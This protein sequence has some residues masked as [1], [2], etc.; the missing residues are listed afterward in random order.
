MKQ[1]TFYWYALAVLLLTGCGTAKLGPSGQKKIHGKTFVIIGASSGFGRGVAEQLGAYKA[2]VVLAARRGSVLEE[3]AAGIRQA[4]GTALVV[5][6]DISDPQAV[7]HLAEAAV[8]RYGTVDVWINM[9]GVGAIGRF[10]EIPLADQARL[11]DVNLTGFIYGSYA[12]ITLFRKQGYGTLINMGSV[13]SNSPIAYHASYAATK[14]GIL[15]LGQAINQE[16]RLSGHKQIK[17]VTIKPWAVDTPFWRH[18]ANYSGGTPRMAAMDPPEK[19][20]NA[21]IR[22]AIRP[23]KQAAVGGKAKVAVFF[24]RLLPHFTERISANIAHKYQVENAPPAPPTS[25]SVH[26]PMEAGTG[27]DDGVRQRMKKEKEARRKSQP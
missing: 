3:I 24:H 22:R 11:V 10:W 26:E 6:M 8:T 19:V 14:A 13:E 17:V 4:G 21:V 18:A 1:S 7:E 23:R 12:A 27:V 16:L 5:P 2:N 25:G 9:A 20:I 15:N